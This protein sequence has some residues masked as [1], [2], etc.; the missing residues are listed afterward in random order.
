VRIIEPFPR[1]CGSAMMAFPRSSIGL[2]L[3]SGPAIPI[4]PSYMRGMAAG[5]PVPREVR[6]L[7]ISSVFR[8]VSEKR[9]QRS[10]SCWL[11]DFDGTKCWA[12][13]FSQFCGPG[14][15]AEPRPI[16]REMDTQYSQERFGAPFPAPDHAPMRCATRFRG[17]SQ[18]VVSAWAARQ[19]TYTLYFQLTGSNG[20]FSNG[21]SDVP[22]FGTIDSGKTLPRPGK[23]STLRIREPKT[24]ALEVEAENRYDLSENG[25]RPTITSTP[26]SPMGQVAR[27]LVLTGG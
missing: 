26:V 6:G 8:P 27:K 15:C 14:V 7:P 23:A 11:G 20:W 25:A 19:Q 4:V 22:T 18:S 9:T 5:S 16:E 12:A 3:R 24:Q 2:F 13:C 1:V 10:D 21:F 17:S